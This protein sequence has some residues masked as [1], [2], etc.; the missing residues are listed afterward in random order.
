MCSYNEHVIVSRTVEAGAAD[1]VKEERA[2]VTSAGRAP[3]GMAGLAKG[4]AVIE[5]FGQTAARL[6]VSDAARLTNI[7]RAAARRCLLTLTELGYLAHDGKYFQ[8]TPRM[9]RLGVAYLDTA[10]LPA[11][12]Q[13]HL[14]SARDRLAES[15]SLAVW[16][17][18][19]AVF[20]ARAE[21]ERLVS[22]GVRVGARL[23]A[24]C[25]ATGKVLLA[26]LGEDEIAA[27]LTL[28]GWPKRTVHTL[29]TAEEIAQAVRAAGADGF[30][31]SDEELEL[32]MRAMAVPV[33]DARGR[34]VAAMSVSTSTARVS[35]DELR[36]RFLPV[37]LE[38]SARLGR[39]L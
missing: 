16:Q 31:T 22:T 27:Y 35:S 26:G 6:T 20:V 37:L 33:R 30:A 29:V 25:S 24:H 19:W 23:P 14:I 13:P 21:A 18:G 5:A 1:G 7:T 17:D 39:I 4:L 28:G 38:H 3:E 2:Q 8:P 36:D 32:G 10:S 15:V 12:A 9:L 34:T 11:L